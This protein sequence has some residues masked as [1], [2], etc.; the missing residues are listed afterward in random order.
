MPEEHALDRTISPSRYLERTTKAFW[1]GRRVWFSWNRGK[2]ITKPQDTNSTERHLSDLKQ[3]RCPSGLRGT[4]QVRVA[5]EP[6]A[7]EKNPTRSTFFMPLL[8]C[9]VI[10]ARPMA[11]SSSCTLH[12][13]F[14][15][16]FLFF[17]PLSLLCL[18][19]YVAVRVQ[20]ACRD[21][22]RQIAPSSSPSSSF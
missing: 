12:R 20:S 4:T 15:S 9:F 16:I 21:P 19:S 6:A 2:A 8:F 22:A 18:C 7:G 11:S 1:L 17:C 5:V 3:L 10:V 14:S 13:L